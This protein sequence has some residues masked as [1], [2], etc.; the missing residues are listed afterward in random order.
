MIDT[1]LSKSNQNIQ[2]KSLSFTQDQAFKTVKI[3]RTCICSSKHVKSCG[4]G[5]GSGSPKE[6]IDRVKVSSQTD[7]Q[8]DKHY[9]SNISLF[10]YSHHHH[11]RCCAEI[12]RRGIKVIRLNRG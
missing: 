5:S 10:N 7:R 12:R 1:T 6:Y 3:S 2:Y 8:T 11:H 4:S 9:I